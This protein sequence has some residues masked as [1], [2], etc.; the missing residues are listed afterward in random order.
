MCVGTILWIIV[1]SVFGLMGLAIFLTWWISGWT[2]VRVHYFHKVR[3]RYKTLDTYEVTSSPSLFGS[4]W[5]ADRPGYVTKAYNYEHAL[6]R[7]FN[8]YARLYHEYHNN[9]RDTPRETTEQWGRFRIRNTRTKW[10]RYYKF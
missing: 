6:E 10:T 8:R 9:A 4:F 7:Y 1:G 2:C 5:R 3:E